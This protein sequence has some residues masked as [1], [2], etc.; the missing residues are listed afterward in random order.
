MVMWVMYPKRILI[1]MYMHK[2]PHASSGSSRSIF[3]TCCPA[4]AC[5]FVMQRSKSEPK[6]FNR[7]GLPSCQSV[8]KHGDGWNGTRPAQEWCHGYG[9]DLEYEIDNDTGVLSSH[10]RK[11]SFQQ[12]FNTKLPWCFTMVWQ[13]CF[14]TLLVAISRRHLICPV[15]STGSVHAWIW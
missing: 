3:A 4:T 9:Q 15:L 5:Q 6:Q 8:S 2:A 7:V 13:N 14:G 1:P 12:D 11:G 10:S